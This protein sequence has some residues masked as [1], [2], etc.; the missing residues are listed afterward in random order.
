MWL[1]VSRHIIYETIPAPRPENVR[2]RF[3][4]IPEIVTDCFD[5]MLSRYLGASL[6][7]LQF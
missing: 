1:L 5:L 3:E 2:F 6:V 4:P 7:K